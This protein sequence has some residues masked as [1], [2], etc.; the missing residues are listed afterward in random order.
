MQITDRS[1]ITTRA[2]CL[3]TQKALQKGWKP[4]VK[5][6]FVLCS[7]GGVGYA[8][9]RTTDGPEPPESAEYIRCLLQNTR[10]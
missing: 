9:H 10:L 3:K 1:N 7:V 4:M 6:E 2:K 8:D 5:V